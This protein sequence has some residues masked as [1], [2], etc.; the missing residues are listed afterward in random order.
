MS[1]K[2]KLINI[3]LF[4]LF[5]I[6]IIAIPASKEIK[7]QE[8]IQQTEQPILT[9]NSTVIESYGI[10]QETILP[11]EEESEKYYMIITA[12]SS[13]EDQTDS[14]PFITASGKT[15]ADGIV[16]NNLLPFG[17]Q[18]KIPEL[19]GDKIFIVED[20]MHSRKGYYHLD[21]WFNTREEAKEFGVREA[22]IEVVQ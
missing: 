1:D 6:S 14:T 16:A 17:T 19:Y 11:L 15:V 2:K 4:L 3:F 8:E 10:D 22:Y 18:I 7:G 5:L 13:T 12:Y 20:R 21:I 9:Q